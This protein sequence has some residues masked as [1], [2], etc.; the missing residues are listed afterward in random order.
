MHLRKMLWGGR[1][2]K[3]QEEEEREEVP[4]WETVPVSGKEC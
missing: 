3:G 4:N 2:V 1:L